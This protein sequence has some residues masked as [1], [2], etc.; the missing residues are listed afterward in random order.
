[1][2]T[3]VTWPSG[4]TSATPTGYNI[5][6]AGELSW[7][8]LSDFLNALAGSA[9][10]T[11]AQKFAVRKA[12]TTPITVSATTD[13][14]IASNLASPGAVAVTLPAGANKQI[15]AI[16]D[17]R[18]DADS[19]NITI[20]PNGSDTVRGAATLVLSSKRECVIL[21]YNSSDTDWKIVS[22]S[23]GNG[24]PFANP[25]TTLGD[26]IYGGASGVAT[27]LAA[28]TSGQ[29]YLSAGGAAPSWTNTITTGKSVVGSADEIQL[30]VKG[31]GTQTNKILDVQT[32]GATSIFNV[33]TAKAVIA[34]IDTGE[35]QISTTSTTG[36]IASGF[37][38]PT[39]TGSTG[40]NSTNFATQQFNWIRV[41][42]VVSVTGICTVNVTAG[43]GTDCIF[44]LTIPIARTDGNFTAG[45]NL[46]GCGTGIISTSSY[47][48]FV[49]R[50]NGTQ[51]VAVEFI[52][53][54]TGLTGFWISYIYNM[55]NN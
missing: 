27:R 14:I 10:S 31:N 25:M 5:P 35:N 43:T 17:D 45:N 9:Q 13:C 18:G 21:C 55:K 33:T 37:F 22:R 52:N 26:T 29:L 12:T 42:N 46:S 50:N 34:A 44:L 28:G 3:S 48:L 39:F 47:P 23:S 49:S 11:T 24:T 41:G 51:Q 30:L 7:A 38:T 1:M 20:T 32:S 36:N 53:S 8:S 15:F 40:T 19:N 16:I 4:T 54:A 6:I 2:P